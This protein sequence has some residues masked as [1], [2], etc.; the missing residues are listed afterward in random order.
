MVYT[1]MVGV[2]C[3]QCLAVPGP[4]DKFSLNPNISYTGLNGIPDF[5][6]VNAEEMSCEAR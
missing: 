5:I 1:G 6:R 4:T 3:C 2:D